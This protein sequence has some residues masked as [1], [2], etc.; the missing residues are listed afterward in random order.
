MR[1]KADFPELCS[2]AKGTSV[3]RYLMHNRNQ[4]KQSNGFIFMAKGADSTAL[5][6]KF[7]ALRPD[8]LLF[9]DIEP[10][11]SNYSVLEA[12]KRLETLTSDLFALNDWATVCIIG[13]TTMPNSIIDQIRKVD[14]QRVML[15]FGEEELRDTID[16]E[17]RWV[18]DQN[19]K[20]HYWPAIF[21]EEGKEDS[22]WPERFPLEEMQQER[23]T[24]NFAKNYMNKPVST[25]N[26]F[27]SEEDIEI[28][29][30]PEGT[31]RTIISVD[32]A[33]TTAKASD[34]TGIAVLCR[35]SD[36]NVYVLFAEQVKMG[37]E[38]LKQHVETLVEKYD[39]RVIYVETNQ[40]GDLWKD[41]FSSLPAKFRSMRQTEKKEL[42]AQRAYHWYQKGKVKHVA[43][44]PVLEEQMYAF[45]RVSHDDV[46]DAVVSGVLYFLKTKSG[47]V[48]VEQY[49]YV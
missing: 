19:I 43:N 2:P 27:W 35:A 10:G 3:G 14:E 45:P 20:T 11:E 16:P 18:I 31:V 38:S 9:D 48:S 44:F 26:G 4:I 12:K 47:R 49:S 33:V 8:V 30:V 40:G 5:G 28:A 15:G 17:L 34:Y 32:P 29:S 46:V 41:V 13:T 36:S 22:F 37:G 24:R 21:D 1:L 7:G 6:M 23:H 39:A 42:R 25:E